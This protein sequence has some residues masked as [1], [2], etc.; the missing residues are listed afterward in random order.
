MLWQQFLRYWPFYPSTKFVLKIICDL[1]FRFGPCASF[2]RSGSSGFARFCKLIV[3]SYERANGQL[4]TPGSGCSR[5]YEVPKKAPK[6][7]F[8]AILGPCSHIQ[9][10]LD[11]YFLTKLAEQQGLIMM[12]LPSDF[13]VAGSKPRCVGTAQLVKKCENGSFPLSTASDK[14]CNPYT[15]Q[16]SYRVCV[17]K[18]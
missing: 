6:W 4:R 8:W 18:R 7:P 16:L 9:S 15:T 2:P 12:K 11:K 3:R 17:I 10:P 13:Q 5:R 1:N 14:L